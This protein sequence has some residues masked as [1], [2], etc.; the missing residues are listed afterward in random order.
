MNAE[1]R[2]IL[3]IGGGIS[4]LTAALEAAE[5]G[6]QVIITEK[7]PYLGG[8][9]AQLHRYFP[10]LCPPTCGLEINSAGSKKI[11]TSAST[12]WRKSPRSA[13]AAG[14]F[15]VTVQVHPRFV[16]DRCVACDAC[17]EAC[18]AFR[19]NDFNYRSGQDQGRLHSL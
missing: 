15:D 8:R 9:V 16:N 18:T 13:A 1:N 11:P 4:G 19:V 2:K 5:A 10:K 12:P 14:N 3:V 7:A 6:S 17:A